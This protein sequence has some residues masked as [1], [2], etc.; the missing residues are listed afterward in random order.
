MILEYKP[1]T[2]PNLGMAALWRVDR[3]Q[4]LVTEFEL[5][6]GAVPG[7]PSEGQWPHM[8]AQFHEAAAG[9][10]RGW[11]FIRKLFGVQP[12]MPP[13]DAT[14]EDFRIWD[15]TELLKHFGLEA[16]QLRAEFDVVRVLWAKAEKAEPRLGIKPETLK[17]EHPDGLKPGLQAELPV[18]VETLHQENALRELGFSEKM[19][20]INVFSS[21]GREETP[22]PAEE[23]RMERKWFIER[24]NDEQWKMMLR[25]SI[26]AVV[27]R[28]A[29][30]NELALR[31]LDRDMSQVNPRSKHYQELRST[32]RDLYD[33]YQQQ[34]TALNEMFPERSIAGKVQ[35]RVTVAAF[36]KAVQAYKADGNNELVD[37]IRT[38]HEIDVELT[39]SVQAPL[40][41][42]RQGQNTFILEGNH[43]LFDPNFRSKLRQST[44]RI[45]DRALPEAWNVIREALAAQP[46]LGTLP[47]LEKGVLPG[48]GDDFEDFPTSAAG[49]EQSEEERVANS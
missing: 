46:G 13:D 29:I 16:G 1:I 42:Y 9:Y 10:P 4:D 33:Q 25:E 17:L 2:E 5:R 8:M 49:G 19:F 28:E 22:R 45:L 43:H 18:V 40:P 44:L 7:A 35:S 21:D 6:A 39:P 36:V 34:L 31:R 26:S 23:N 15:R 27:A 38:A 14:A 48:E 41:A 30:L 20:E 3:F 24:I 37:G 11:Q 12:L 32:K 47:D